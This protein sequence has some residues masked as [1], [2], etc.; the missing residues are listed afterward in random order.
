MRASTI[1]VMLFAMVACGGSGGDNASAVAPTAPVAV[2]AAPKPVL[3]T[4]YGDSTTV[5]YYKAGSGKYEIYDNAPWKML[6]Q[7]LQAQFGSS[8][9]VKLYAQGGASLR[10]MLQG[11]G[12]FPKPLSVGVKDDPSQIAT[13]RFG[14]NDSSQY[15]A[16]TYKGYLVEAVQ[17]MQAAGKTV[18]LEQITPTINYPQ[19]NGQQFADAVDQV[20]AQFGIP[21]VK[22]YSGTASIPG[23]AALLSD[24]MHPTE[25]LYQ[26]ISDEQIPVLAPLVEKLMKG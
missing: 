23:W 10:D 4:Q 15:D 26:K 20:A 18:V 14:L 1:G 19:G 22:T 3:I 16:A 13:I 11:T 25:A 21:V 17:I 9:T 12:S 8:V 7:S 5:G 6:Q 24:D 2:K